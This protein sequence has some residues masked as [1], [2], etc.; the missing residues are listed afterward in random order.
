MGRD[1]WDAGIG[2]SVRKWPGAGEQLFHQGSQSRIPEDK[3]DGGRENG[4]AREGAV[5]AMLEEVALSLGRSIPWEIARVEE[6]K[7]GLA[8]RDGVAS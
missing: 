2:P 3:A 6:G 8:P 5:A 4:F 7:V 1:G